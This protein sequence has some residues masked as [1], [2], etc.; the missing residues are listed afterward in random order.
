MGQ[1]NKLLETDFCY[2]RS[3]WSG[4]PLYLQKL[5]FME[6]IISLYLQKLIPARTSCLSTCA[7][8]CVLPSTHANSIGIPLEKRGA[9]V[10]CSTHIHTQISIALPG[11]KMKMYIPCILFYK[12]HLV[13]ST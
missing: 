6:S 9:V 11:S 4:S 7:A 1:I 13:L 2:R 8:A 5:A 10:N 12:I 3:R